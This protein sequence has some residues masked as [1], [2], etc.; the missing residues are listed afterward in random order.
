MLTAKDPD[1]GEMMRDELIRY[2]MM[3]F[4]LAGHDT[5][6]GLLN[7]AFLSMLQNPRT[8]Q[9]AQGEVDSVLG[10][11][12]IEPR[13]LQKL[14]Y[15]EAILRETLRLYPT[16]P[17][18]TRRPKSK[19]DIFLAGGKYRIQPGDLLGVDLASLHRDPKV[20]GEP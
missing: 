4:L 7:F 9:A 11:G 15:I 13:M 6:S 20:W 8:L 10:D 16:A 1:T 12:P 19:E 18:F 5:T 17:A 3:T 14:P 2:E